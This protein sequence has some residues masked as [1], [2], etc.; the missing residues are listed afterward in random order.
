MSAFEKAWGEGFRVHTLPKHNTGVGEL[1]S[2]MIGPFKERTKG[3]K[4]PFTGHHTFDAGRGSGSGVAGAYYHG[5]DFDI[6]ADEYMS[7]HGAKNDVLDFLNRDPDK[8]SDKIVQMPGGKAFTPLDSTKF[9]QTSRALQGIV[10]EFR[11]NK[12]LANR[13]SMLF[14]ELFAQE[15]LPSYY[16]MDIIRD[17]FDDYDRQKVFKPPEYSWDNDFPWIRGRYGDINPDYPIEGQ[18]YGPMSVVAG[19]LA[20]QSLKGVNTGQL[21][22]I[23]RGS[24]YITDIM[25]QQMSDEERDSLRFPRNRMRRFNMERY[26]ENRRKIDEDRNWW[27]NPNVISHLSED[28][29][30]YGL[31]PMNILLGSMG[32]DRYVPFEPKDRYGMNTQEIT[33]GSVA[34][35]PVKDEWWEDWHPAGDDG[36]QTMDADHLASLRQGSLEQLAD[37]VR[38]NKSMQ[39]HPQ[40][41][42]GG[43]WRNAL[44]E[45]GLYYDWRHG[46][47]D[48]ELS[49][50]MHPHH[51]PGYW[52][53]EGERVAKL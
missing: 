21:R 34:M 6:Q 10:D 43:R 40:M 2:S 17:L 24:P 53:R 42:E 12:R 50:L 4:S 30:H 7:Q 15:Q 19:S 9:Y 31:P 14:P 18:H 20:N 16:Q 39:H 35:P 47:Y 52:E 8:F 22:D 5:G 38:H 23:L 49:R 36:Y 46:G 41:Q 27:Q 44:E 11:R 51:W 28:M 3:S 37:L 25:G 29:E 33:R 26:R 13:E 1:P 48:E 45:A 32:Y